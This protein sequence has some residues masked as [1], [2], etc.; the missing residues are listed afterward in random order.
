[1]T[2]KSIFLTN[3]IYNIKDHVS[4]TI[5]SE[6][7]IHVHSS[8][9]CLDNVQH[10]NLVRYGHFSIIDCEYAWKLIGSIVKNENN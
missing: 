4:L 10:L 5:G 8:H 2:P 1:M 9:S 6:Q 3:I 7:D